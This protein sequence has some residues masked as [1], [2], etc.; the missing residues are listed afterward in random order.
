M[1]TKHSTM[2][3]AVF[4]VTIGCSIL[5]TLLELPAWPIFIGWSLFYLIGANKESV[6]VNL[7]S[8]VGGA[9]LASLTSSLLNYLALGLI[10]NAIIVGIMAALAI[11]MQETIWF[12]MVSMVFIGINMYFALGSVLFGVIL[13]ALG[14]VM[15]LVTNQLI[16]LIDNNKKKK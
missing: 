2:A 9:V 1:R 8:L 7:P 3:L 10:P 12:K 13:P 14:F 4:I 16:I 15:G 11:F 5:T 6:K